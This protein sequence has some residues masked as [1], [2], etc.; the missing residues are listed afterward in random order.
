LRYSLL[1]ASGL[2]VLANLVA[3]TRP[4]NAP[5]IWSW[6]WF[7]PG[8]SHSVADALVLVVLAWSLVALA[9]C[10]WCALARL[11][12]SLAREGV[13]PDVLG[14][15]NGRGIPM[16]AVLAVTPLALVAPIVAMLTGAD[17]GAFSWDLKES[18]AVVVCAAY[19]LAA[20]S[21]PRFLWSIDEISWAP[22]AGALVAAAGATAVAVTQLVTDLR[23]G[24]WMAL[25]LLAISALSGLL[26][27]WWVGTSTELGDRYVGMHDDALASAVVLPPDPP[28]GVHADA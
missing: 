26:M 3:T 16:V 9:M 15:V 14:R 10:V 18:A 12:F 1:L 6:R 24:A 7:A 11:L 8:A 4:P 20:L 21:L 22:V 28:R 23:D 2:F 5:S 19:A 25:G 13:L 27:R 17:V